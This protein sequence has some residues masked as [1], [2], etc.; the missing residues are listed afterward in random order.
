MREVAGMNPL[1]WRDAYDWVVCCCI[2]CIVH[3]ALLI[4]I[5]LVLLHV[6]DDSDEILTVEVALQETPTEPVVF[7]TPKAAEIEREEFVWTPLAAA[8]RDLNVEVD[9]NVDAVS[10]ARGG[11]K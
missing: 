3:L 1:K 7:E 2:S 4:V 9:L 11:R 8:P 10:S 6:S 5:A